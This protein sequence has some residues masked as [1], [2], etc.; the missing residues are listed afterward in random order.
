[1]MAGR[2]S[3]RRMS[4]WFRLDDVGGAILTESGGERYS[5]RPLMQE[6]AL[7]ARWHKKTIYCYFAAHLDAAL[8]FFFP[9]Q[10]RFEGR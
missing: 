8:V 1:M 9:Q 4:C 10:R 6:H 3:V 7:Q 5:G 2:R